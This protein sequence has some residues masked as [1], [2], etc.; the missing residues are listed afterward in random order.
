[1]QNIKQYIENTTPGSILIPS[2]FRNFGT[3]N[4]IDQSLSRLVKDNYIQRI[5]QG[6]Y[7]KPKMSRFGALPPDDMDIA[8]A[9]AK[10]TRCE[11]Q[12]GEATAANMLGLTT[13]VPAKLLF[14][15]NGATRIRKIR[16][17][18]Y[19]FKNAAPKR[20]A[21]AG[22]KAGIIAQALRFLGKENINKTTIKKI[23]EQLTDI[24]KKN[25]ILKKNEMPAWIQD[26][27][28][29]IIKS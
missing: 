25:L 3:R 5:S 23:A 1:M 19:I 24:D 7:T 20:M 2:D 13:Q 18:K 10:N 8:Q 17:K 9:I 27:I 4:I 12:P 21:G 14:Y 16:N 11:L 6:L 29:L 22:E 28:A 15:T 26:I